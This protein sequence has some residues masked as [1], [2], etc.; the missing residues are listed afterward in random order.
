[1]ALLEAALLEAFTAAAGTEVVASELFL[2]QL[3]VAHDA[4]TA[5]DLRLGGEPLPAF[6]HRLEKN[7][8]SSKLRLDMGHLPF[9]KTRC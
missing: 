8:C 4:H 9:P 7:G 5:F 2:Q 6:A 1:M 3:A